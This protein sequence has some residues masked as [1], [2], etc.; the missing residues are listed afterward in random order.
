MFFI[1]KEVFFGFKN[2][3]RKFYKAKTLNYF[4]EFIA[5]H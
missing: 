2:D 4:F 3:K 1:R 5:L